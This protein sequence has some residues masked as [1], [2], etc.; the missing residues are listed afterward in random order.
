MNVLREIA[1]S[2]LGRLF[3]GL[4]GGFILASILAAVG[5]VPFGWTMM[6]AVVLAA[7]GFAQ[8]Q[9]GE[10]LGT[11]KKL[12]GWV[13]GF[14]VGTCAAVIVLSLVLRAL[15]TNIAVCWTAFQTGGFGGIKGVI[16][17]GGG[18][19]EN[20][21]WVLLFIFAVTLVAAWMKGRRRTV[22]MIFSV[23]IL[24]AFVQV[25]MTETAK[26]T[27]RLEFD[28]PAARLID[29]AGIALGISGSE[30]PLLPTCADP[31][32]VLTPRKPDAQ[33]PLRADC[34][35]RVQVKLPAGVRADVQPST[36]DGHALC[37]QSW[38]ERRDCLGPTESRSL[39]GFGETDWAD[40]AVSGS[41]TVT[42][43]LLDVRKTS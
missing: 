19:S 14:A 25:K 28:K 40:F 21:L 2:A 18:T 20:L 43:R 35:A 4:L 32:R 7:L 33:F 15:G 1:N 6:A 34:A 16:L 38:R 9:F 11:L 22:T 29:N 17:K 23:A 42:V 8:A 12:G 26:A 31:P 10:G 24:V 30:H 5:V 37:V 41:G 27:G 13:L 39:R 36:P 3:L